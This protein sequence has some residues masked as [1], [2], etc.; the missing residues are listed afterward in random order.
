MSSNSLGRRILLSQLEGC[1]SEWVRNNHNWIRY[2]IDWPDGSR[3]RGQTILNAAVVSL[4][5]MM[6]GRYTFG[7]N[8][9]FVFHALDSVLRKL[10]NLLPPG[11]RDELYERIEEEQDEESGTA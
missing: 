3:I 8:E 9:L 6:Q 1:I 4:D 2:P 5:E 7:A 11:A 10:E